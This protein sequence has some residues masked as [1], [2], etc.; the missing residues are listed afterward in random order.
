[1]IYLLSKLQLTVR[2]ETQYRTKQ[3]P[4]VKWLD[5]VYYGKSGGY[6]TKFRVFL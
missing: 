6:T 5:F 1:M 3:I 2:F 4:D